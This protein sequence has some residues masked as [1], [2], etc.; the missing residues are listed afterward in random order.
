M[1]HDVELWPISVSNDTELHVS[2][3]LH[4]LSPS[5]EQKERVKVWINS[6]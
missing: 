6:I 5:S 4:C 2:F 3:L 1:Q